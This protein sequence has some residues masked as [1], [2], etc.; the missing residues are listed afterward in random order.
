MGILN[1]RDLRNSVSVTLMGGLGRLGILGLGGLGVLGGLS[2]AGEAPVKQETQAMSLEQEAR[3][4]LLA[5]FQ[6]KDPHAVDRWFADS[7]VQHDPAVAD[8]IAGMK[9]FAREI[10]ESPGAH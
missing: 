5:I 7:F 6:K 9:A 1:W 4:V 2:L 8:G 3:Q 10:A